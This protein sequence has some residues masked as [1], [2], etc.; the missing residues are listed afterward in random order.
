MECELCGRK[1]ANRRAIVEGATLTVC[2][3]CV[4]AGEEVRTPVRAAAPKRTIFPEELNQAYVHGFANII[5]KA[6]QA[7]GLTQEQLADR[8]GVK[9][10]FIRRMEEGW[11]AP[12][13]I[14]A[15]V[16]KCLKIRLIEMVGAEANKKPEK[17]EP[18]TIGDLIEVKE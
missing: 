2:G 6:R 15:K 13:V 12:L 5:R 16:E 4:P 14:A 9:A 10:S 3:D 18:M 8:T 11:E 1:N 7:S 17:S